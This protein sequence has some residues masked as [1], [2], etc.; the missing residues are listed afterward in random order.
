H[1]VGALLAEHHDEHGWTLSLDLAEAEAAR[2]ASHAY[3]EPL[4]PLLAGQDIP[5]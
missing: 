2:I 5:T 4:R 1:E 3:G